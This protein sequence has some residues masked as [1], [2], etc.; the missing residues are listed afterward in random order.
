MMSYPVLA[1]ENNPFENIEKTEEGYILT[2]D[3]IIKLANYIA[4]LEAEKVKLE[5]KLEQANIELEKA[6]SNNGKNDIIKR[7]G[8]GLTGAGLAALIVLIAQGLGG[9]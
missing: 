7:V 8:D 5:A 3:Q 4:E 6:Y 1:E 2:E 9:N